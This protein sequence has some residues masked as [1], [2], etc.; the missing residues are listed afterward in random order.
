[1]GTHPLLRA[2]VLL[3][4]AAFLAGIAGAQS[5]PF[6]QLIQLYDYDKALP[7]DLQEILVD[8]HDGTTIE[9]ISF[10]V[11]TGHRADGILVL[12]KGKGRGG[13]IVWLHSTGPFSWLPD[14]I[15]MAKAGAIS[16]IVSPDLGSPDLPAQQYR[17]AMV[18]AVV[19]I[20]RSIDFLVARQDVDPKRLAFVGHSFGAMLGAVATGVDKRFAAAVFEVG[21]PGMTFH[22]RTSPVPWAA[23]HRRRLGASL[24]EYLKVIEPIDAIHYIGHASATTLLFQS[25][26][27]DP[28]VSRQDSLDFFNAASEPK[29]L[30][31]YDTAH[32][33]TDIAAISDRARFLAEQLQLQPIGPILREKIG[34]K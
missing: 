19:S 14:A 20:R 27:L 10:N 11:S 28:G 4:C 30:K 9:W 12:P 25:A 23:G 8:N 34:Q 22:L 18:T 1:M 6:N 2:G 16:L 26:R 21:L 15:L 13:A 29:Q 32:D 24:D 3:I 5:P 17:D 33:V 31:W 7:F